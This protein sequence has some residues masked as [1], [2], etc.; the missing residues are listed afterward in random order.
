MNR[1]K[2]LELL[3]DDVKMMQGA[4]VKGLASLWFGFDN[5]DFLARL[6]GFLPL[7]AP[8]FVQGI[9]DVILSFGHFVNG[10]DVRIFSL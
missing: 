2:L 5:D 9:D 6:S 8:I 4:F 10:C 7:F 3:D 1:F